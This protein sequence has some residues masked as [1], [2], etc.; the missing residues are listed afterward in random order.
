MPVSGLVLS[1]FPGIDLLGRGFESE[2][3]CV[4]RGPDPIFGG[5]IE[6][7][8]PPDGVFEGVIGGS[9]CQDFSCARRSEPTGE[10]VRLLAEFTRCVR[11]ADPDW[12]LLEN[13]PG[14]PTVDVPFYRVQRFN[15]T[16]A[17]CGGNQRRLRTFQFG[18]RRGDQLVISRQAV[19]G[20]RLSAAAMAT[21]GDRKRRRTWDDFCELQGLPRDF[22]L[23][24][25]T[26]TARYKAVGNGVDVR[27]ARVLAI[28]VMR[29]RDTPAGRLCV[30]DCGRIVEGKGTHASPA[31][32]KR[33]ERRRRDGTAVP[34]PGPDS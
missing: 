15:L 4:V 7:F 28:A 26:I 13:V 33:M 24:G 18:S 30:C 2:G 20:R 31:C 32:R 10:G 12:F 21:E 27:V 17:E 34:S 25:W 1:L 29:R 3:F 19:T 8:F 5:R 16:A 6:T 22:E 9:P 11:R 23:P 14:V